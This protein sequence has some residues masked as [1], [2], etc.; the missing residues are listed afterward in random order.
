MF[1]LHV[2][3]LLDVSNLPSDRKPLQNASQ[4]RSQCTSQTRQSSGTLKADQPSLLL[5]STESRYGAIR[6]SHLVSRGETNE[7]IMSRA[8]NLPSILDAPR[9]E[10]CL[11]ENPYVRM[12]S[13]LVGSVVHFNSPA[14]DRRHPTQ[15]KQ[16]YGKECKVSSSNPS[17]SFSASLRAHH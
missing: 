10:T 3:I 6:L 16:E 5:T 11:G 15:S 14:K 8:D 13:F 12:V 9:C 1:D 7:W 4:A 17:S 2:S